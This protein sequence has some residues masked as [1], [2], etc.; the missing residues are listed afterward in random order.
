MQVFDDVSEFPTL[1]TELTQQGIRDPI[2]H[3]LHCLPKEHQQNVLRRLETA[4]HEETLMMTQETKTKYLTDVKS[5]EESS[6]VSL[7]VE[8]LNVGRALKHNYPECDCLAFHAS[9]SNNHHAAEAFLKWIQKNDLLLD[10]RHHIYQ[11]V[12][13]GNDHTP[14]HH[15][16]IQVPTLEICKDLVASQTT[17]YCEHCSDH[18]YDISFRTHTFDRSIKVTLQNHIED[19]VWINE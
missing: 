19:E 18:V 7:E 1:I 3:A 8:C 10:S 4:I 5:I 14:A 11:L 6:F 13:K 17:I 16:D 2:I 15:P 12:R 9:F